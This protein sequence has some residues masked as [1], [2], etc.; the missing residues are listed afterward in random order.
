[1]SL[2]LVIPEAEMNRFNTKVREYATVAG[3]TLAEAMIKQ[4]SKF[5]INLGARL[6]KE[7]PGKGDITRERLALLQTKSEGVRVRATI[8]DSTRAQR[9]SALETVQKSGRVIRPGFTLKGKMSKEERKAFRFLEKSK[10]LR[11]GRMLNAQALAVRAE[12]KARESGR[13]FTGYAARIRGLGQV[14]VTG[15]TAKALRHFGRYAQELAN[16]GI[17]VARDLSSIAFHWGR[18]GG[19][20]Q[21]TSD[22]GK[23]M[24]Q[25]QNYPHI[26]AALTETTADIQAYLTNKVAQNLSRI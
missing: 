4:A 15:P 10:N 25:P 14:G 12:L 5:S 22:I 23:A 9:M 17:Q 1:M 3:M 24:H 13:G 26:A 19:D 21:Q 16:V 11:T 2:Q 6:R 8:R 20:A 7:S 18:Q